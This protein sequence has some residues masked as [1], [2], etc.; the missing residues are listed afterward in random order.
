MA[1]SSK[2]LFYFVS[3]LI[4]FYAFPGLINEFYKPIY[5]E[6]TETELYPLIKNTTEISRF[7]ISIE[8]NRDYALIRFGKNFKDAQKESNVIQEESDESNI[9]KCNEQDE[10]QCQ[11]QYV[12]SD[13]D[14]TINEQLIL[15]HSKPQLH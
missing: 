13:H 4:S 9:E 10:N 15:M 5:M 12:N 7:D 1:I 6:V 11:Y 8:R 3:A 2:I 14:N